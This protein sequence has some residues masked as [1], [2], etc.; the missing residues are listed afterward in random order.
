MSFSAK[1]LPFSIIIILSLALAFDFRLPMATKQPVHPKKLFTTMAQTKNTFDLESNQLFSSTAGSTIAYN[2]YLENTGRTIASYTLT[3]SSNKGYYIE[4]W[5]DTDQI[6]SGETQLI[7]PQGSTITLNAGE[8]A[9]LIVKVTIPTDATSGTVDTTTIRAVNAL[10]SAYDSATITTTVNAYLPYPSNLIQLG[11]DPNF[12]TPPPERI[13][14]KAVYYT[15]N[16]TFIFFRVAEASRPNPTAFFYCVYLDTKAGGQQIDSYNYDYMLSS[17]GTL[18]QWNGTNWLNSGYRIYWQVDGTSMV[19]W[20]DLNNL[21]LDMQE[22]HILACST[23][24]DYTWKDEVGPF[25]I[26]RNNI[27]EIPLIAV[28]VLSFAIYFTISRR[29]KKKC[30]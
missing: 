2:L 27:S 5:R 12:P 20:A 26:L 16:G 4:V 14:A 10:S 18:Y 25:A 9:T 17:D 7:P 6:G 1:L 11:S 28:P 22:I 29:N 13:D 24:K 21:D 8:V 19:L 30:T 3:A 15:N 23:T